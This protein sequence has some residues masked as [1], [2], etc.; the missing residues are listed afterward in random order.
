MFNIK[1]TDLK[2]KFYEQIF[3]VSFINYMW[4]MCVMLYNKAK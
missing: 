3:K 1:V 4:F 2:S